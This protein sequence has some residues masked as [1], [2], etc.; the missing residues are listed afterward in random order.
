VRAEPEPRAWAGWDD[1]RTARIYERFYVRHSRYR[2]A[3]RALVAHAQLAEGQRVL[4]VGAGT[5]RTAE[6]ALPFIGTAGRVLC[7][8]PAAAMREAGERRLREPR[9]TWTDKLPP[10]PA[11]WGFDRIL[12]GA[13]LWQLLP[14]AESISRL[15]RLLVPGGA[16][17]FNIPS[18][19]LCE[20]DQPGG[21]RDPMLL[22]LTSFV[23]R[24]PESPAGVTTEAMQGIPRS[25][26]E[27]EALLSVAGLSP[28]PWS[29]RLR[30]TQPAY[31][32][33]LGIP[34]VSE[35][36]FRGLPPR[37]RARRLAEAYERVDRASWR[38]ERWLGWT[39][40]RDS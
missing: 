11:E 19:Y 4:D 27:M 13:S 24:S 40:W 18:L 36:L 14:L 39:A 1:P 33:W 25:A 21:G 17:C 29:F 3:N 10:D 23:R 9:V 5:G 15:A 28:K 12:G 22:E 30:L 6:A 37:E 20:P 2:K 32:D 31:R 16:L 8:E 35:G 34:V 38:C 26:D 7:V